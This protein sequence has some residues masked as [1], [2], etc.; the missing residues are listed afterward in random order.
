MDQI[1]LTLIPGLLIAII[2]SLVTVRL[3]IRQFYSQKWWERKWDEY[4]GMVDALH[5]LRNHSFRELSEIELGMK[6]SEER[7]RMLVED[8]KNGYEQLAKAIS[9]GSFVFSDSTVKVLEELQND[10][11]RFNRE[12]EDPLRFLEARVSAFD[13]A[14]S[15]FISLARRDLAAE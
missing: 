12:M 10:L 3:S 1:L 15:E 14:I 13:K 9:V 7:R 11:V 6:I 4:R 2:T 5:D 8:A